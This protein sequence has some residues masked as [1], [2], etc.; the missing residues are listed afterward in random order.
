MAFVSSPPFNHSRWLCTLTGPHLIIIAGSNLC[1]LYDKD[2]SD[3]S[4]ASA[5]TSSPC[6]QSNPH[7]QIICS[8]RSK[9]VECG[10]YTVV[11]DYEATATSFIAIGKAATLICYRASARIACRARYCFTISVS[12][13]VCL[14]V[15][16]IV[17]LYQTYEHSTIWYT[18]H[19]SFFSSPPLLK[20]F[21]GIPH[22]GR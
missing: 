12:L 10:M 5:V 18:L 2:R 3:D 11:R 13:S 21:K 22:R 4:Y 1:S 9:S 6:I 20:R 15:R 8:G 17:V 14:S 7:R 16:H 19:T